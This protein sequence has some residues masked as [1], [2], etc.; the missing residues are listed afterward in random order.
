MDII[1]YQYPR[2]ALG[3]HGQNNLMHC[4]ISMLLYK[5][6]TTKAD[7]DITNELKNLTPD[8]SFSL[9][10]METLKDLDQLMEIFGKAVDIGK[11]SDPRVFH[12]TYQYLRVYHINSIS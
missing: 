1:N 4:K 7:I 3:Q 6:L 8:V 5:Y 12:G 11:E 2:K 10:N 9:S